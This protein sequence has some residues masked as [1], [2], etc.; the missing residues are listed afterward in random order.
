MAKGVPIHL[1]HKTIPLAI[2]SLI[3]DKKM[4]ATIRLFNAVPIK[5]IGTAKASEALMRETIQHGFLFAPE[6]IYNYS[7]R[8]LFELT[9]KIGLTSEQMNS[10]FHKSWKKVREADITQLILEQMMHYITTYGFEHLG[11]YDERSVYIPSETLD[12]P[13]IEKLPLR[14]IK[15][16]TK[17]ELRSKLLG[18]LRVGLALR[19]TTISDVLEI[20]QYVGLTAEEI[21]T[22]KNREVAIALY[23]NLNTIPENPVEFLRYVIF[24]CTGRTLLIKDV[25]TIKAIKPVASAQYAGQKRPMAAS[26]KRRVSIRVAFRRKYLSMADAKATRPRVV[27]IMVKITS[28]WKSS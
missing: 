20:V 1:L 10:T 5:N 25:A 4:E 19:D 12:I 13:D 11:I 24:K 6:A 3:Q 23:D 9:E 7:E 27:V 15:G 2:T 26:Q 14:V 16:Y 21:A 17:D 28:Q 8:E 18:M 22:I